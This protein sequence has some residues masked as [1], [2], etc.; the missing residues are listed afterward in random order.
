MVTFFVYLSFLYALYFATVLQHE[1][2]SYNNKQLK[3]TNQNTPEQLRTLPSVAL[4][5]IH[6]K[7]NFLSIG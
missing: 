2:S 3:Q 6:E 1:L 4:G 7:L 5:S